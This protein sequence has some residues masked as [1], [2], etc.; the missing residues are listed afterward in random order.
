MAPRPFKLHIPSLRS[1]SLLAIMV[2]GASGHIALREFRVRDYHE[3]G[4]IRPYWCPG[5]FHVADFFSESK[6]LK[7][8]LLTTNAY[9]FCYF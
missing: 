4:K 5:P 3:M 1:K 8:N 6:L 2:S 7:K 9:R